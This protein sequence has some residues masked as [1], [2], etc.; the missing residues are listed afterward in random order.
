[1]TLNSSVWPSS[2]RGIADRTH[3][4]ERAR[5]ERA[6]QVDVD[7]EAALTR[8]LIMPVTISPFWN[9]SSR[10]VHVRVRLAFSRDRRVSPKPSSTRIECDLDDVAD[11]D[12]ELAALVEKLLGR[13]DGLGFQAGVDDDH[14]V[15][16]A[17]DDAGEDRTRLDL[18]VREAL[19]EQLCKRFSS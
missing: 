1:M 5:Q 15:V 14:V 9:A 16:H 2:S 11:F 12:V 17:D 10:R 18:L 7:R 13:D 4:D 19:F 3:V 6:D 8:P